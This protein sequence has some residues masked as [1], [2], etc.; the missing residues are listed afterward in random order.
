[1][2][3]SDLT[4]G[5]PV[6]IDSSDRMR[7][8][9]AIVQFFKE[10]DNITIIVLEA[11][12]KSVIQDMNGVTR[13]FIEDS[14]PLYHKTKHIKELFDNT[15]TRFVGIWDSDVLVSKRMIENAMNQLRA[16]HADM[17]I[18]YNGTVCMVTDPVLESFLKRS[19]E[20]PPNV[21]FLLENQKEM[22]TYYGHHACGGAYIVNKEKHF[23][24][25][26]ENLKF[27]SWGPE[28]LE[29]YKRWEI[30]DMRVHRGSEPMF[31][32]HHQRGSSWYVNEEIRH[33]LGLELIKTC[34]STKEELVRRIIKQNN[35]L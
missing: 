4:I 7:N 18:P 13:I 10:F 15:A 9:I 28:D 1:M 35:D 3:Y 11:D 23:E 26:G 19:K 12:A 32:L 17:S 6:R 8:L 20:V 33:Q 16:N 2:G 25:G 24:A 34:R 30:C 14:N 21:D 27:T 29:R 22:A 31:H 5:I